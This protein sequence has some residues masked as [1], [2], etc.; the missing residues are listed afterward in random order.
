MEIDKLWQQMKGKQASEEQENLVLKKLEASK[1]PLKTLRKNLIG[2]L[3]FGLVGVVIGVYLVVIYPEISLRLTLGALIIIYQYFNWLMYQRIKAFD[4][5]LDN[6]D[7]PIIPTLQQQLD[8]TRK[9][10]KLIEFQ[11]MLF[12]PLAYLAGLL[13]GGTTEEVTADDLIVNVSFLVKGMGLSLLTMPPLYFLLKWM[14]KK[15]FG[16]YI[17]QTEKILLTYEKDN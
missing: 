6:W 14:H 10:I 9:T 11:S 3:I 5:L 13:I 16:D 1:N 15:A 8:L 7:Q 17:A 12:L 2:N 4:R